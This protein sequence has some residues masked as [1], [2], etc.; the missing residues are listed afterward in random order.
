MTLCALPHDD[1]SRGVPFKKNAP[2]EGHLHRQGGVI[3][4]ICL[5]ARPMP[6]PSAVQPR[7]SPRTRSHQGCRWI[8]LHLAIPISHPFENYVC[9]RIVKYP[10]FPRPK[11]NSYRGAR[12]PEVGVI[13]PLQGGSTFGRTPSPI[14]FYPPDGGFSIYRPFAVRTLPVERIMR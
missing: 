12:G 7:V 6:S 10:T 13:N 9:V 5:L 1:V 11:K 14:W 2:T 4:L 3:S 8:V